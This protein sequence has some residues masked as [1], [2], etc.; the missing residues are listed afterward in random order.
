VFAVTSER[1]V[2]WR[3]ILAGVLASVGLGAPALFAQDA[4]SNDTCLTCHGEPS[5]TRADGRPVV[6]EPQAFAQSAHAP[7]ACV[8]C[9]TD[10]ARTSEFPHPDRLARVDCA[11]CHDVAATLGASVHAAVP[12]SAGGPLGCVACHGPPHRI[13]PAADPESPT[14]K[15]RI[16]DTCGGCH[17][18]TVAGSGARGAAVAAE[19]A[20]SIHGLALTRTTVA[21]TCSD[22][23]TGHDVRRAADPASRV[24]ALN[25]PATCG[26]CHANQQRLYGDS[27]H[28][29]L[30][31]SGA[32]S[33]PHCASCHTAHSIRPTA[34]PE[35]QLTAVAQCGQCH[36]EALATYRDTFHGQ[37][38]AL[39]FTPVAQCADCHRSHQVFRTSDPRSSVAEANRVATCQACHPSANLN[40]VRYQPHAN[41]DDR[42]RLPALYYAARLMNGLLVG[43]FAFFGVHSLLWFV[44]ERT[45]RSDDQR[46]A[47][48]G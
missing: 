12:A 38:T 20:D 37:V 7:F 36:R 41:K 48:R 17:G 8:D 43:T 24:H 10:L 46:P 40:F 31:R 26:T 18:E 44:R 4:P 25:V 13:R 6:V 5:M 19:F 34:T 30:L 15:L 29:A 33:A 11:A 9:H 2:R 47:P 16:A 35:W 3:T 28:A 22:C 27:V 32:P 21:P 45:G 1:D 23:H 14:N 39:G 42:E